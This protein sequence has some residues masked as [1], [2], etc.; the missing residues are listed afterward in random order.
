M[1][2]QVQ[3]EKLLKNKIFAPIIGGPRSYTCALPTT[4]P[5]CKHFDGDPTAKYPPATGGIGALPQ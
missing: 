3:V 1:S 4:I 2:M 5:T